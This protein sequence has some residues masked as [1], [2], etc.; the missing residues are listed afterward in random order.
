MADESYAATSLLEFLRQAPEQGLLNSAVAKSRYA[1]AEQLFTELDVNERA[2][3]R[4]ID[5]DDL[6]SR[7]HKIEN[8]TIRPDV[9]ELYKTRVQAALTDYLNWL[10]DPHSYVSIGGEA[11]RR[12]KRDGVYGPEH[13][14]ERSALE[15]IVLATSERKLDLISVPLRET[16]TVYVSNLPL[17]LSAAEARKIAKVIE[18]MAQPAAGEPTD[19]A[20]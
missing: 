4:L 1:A 13:T 9:V 11:S 20:L 12:D 17:D 14:Q 15:E 7:L 19:D 8:S 6:V 5:L 2:D 3:I 18:A 10:G 16:V